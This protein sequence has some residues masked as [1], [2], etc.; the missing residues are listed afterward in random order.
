MPH[1]SSLINFSFVLDPNEQ[2]YSFY[3]DGFEEE[4]Q[5]RYYVK[6]AEELKQE[7]K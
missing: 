4:Q 6:M 7:E 2:N 5:I 3:A 1:I